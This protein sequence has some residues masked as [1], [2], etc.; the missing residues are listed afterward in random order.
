MRVVIQRVLEASVTVDGR[1]IARIGAGLL[2][3]LVVETGDDAGDVDW[4]CAKTAKLRVFAD[5]EGKMNLSVVEAGG[6]VMVLSQF[7]LHAST[8][9]GNRPSFIRAA[10]PAIS[11]PL[12]EAFCRRMTEE[13][14]KP[15]ASGVFGADMKVALLNDGP[16]TIVIDSRS[17]E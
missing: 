16:V 15:V 5:S 9:K 2:V 6:E 4:L 11:E 1:E 8:Q 13:S 12:Y 3:L 17:R 7:T 10:V 14:G